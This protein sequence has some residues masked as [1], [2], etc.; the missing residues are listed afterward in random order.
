M[1]PSAPM[2][3]RRIRTLLATLTLGL[4]LGL[5]PAAAAQAPPSAGPT[6]GA[7]IFDASVV[8]PLR[9][10]AVAVGAVFFVPAAMVSM[11][12]GGMDAL[13]QAYEKMIGDPYEAAF[14]RPL[15]EF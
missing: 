7:K 11:P 8:R 15:G 10:A 1:L 13:D 9:V 12:V 3:A 4:S 14:I 2:R 5:A 6:L